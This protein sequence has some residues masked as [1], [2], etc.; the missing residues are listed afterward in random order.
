M[1][2]LPT[3]LLLAI[4]FNITAIDQPT[5]KPDLESDLIAYYTFNECNARDD[6]GNGSNGI[7]YGD[8]GCWCGIEDDGLLF[9]GVNDYVEFQGRVNQYFGNTDFTISFYFKPERYNIFRQSLISK[10]EACDLEHILDLSV[11]QNQKIV[12]TMLYESPLKYYNNISPGIAKNGWHHFTLVR[13]GLKVSTYI[14]GELQRESFKCNGVDLSNNAFL[15]FSNS[16]CILTGEG[17]RFKGILDEL[18]IYSRALD[19]SEIQSLYLLFPIENAA[20]DCFS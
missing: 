6:T 19:K 17:R 2:L 5:Y 13:E 1:N 9:D 4:T 3:A 16:P 12:H 15:S 7:L 10:R 14:N 18:R 20:S 11:D 8:V